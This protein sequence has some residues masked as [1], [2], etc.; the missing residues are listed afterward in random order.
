[1][2]HGKPVYGTIFYILASLNIKIQDG[3]R[4][5]YSK[6]NLKTNGHRNQCNTTFPTKCGMESEFLASL[7]YFDQNSRWPPST[8]SISAVVNVVVLLSFELCGIAMCAIPH[9][10][11]NFTWES[12]LK[13]NLL[14]LYGDFISKSIMTFAKKV[15]NKLSK[16][17]IVNKVKS[18]W[19]SSQGDHQK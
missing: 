3:R 5:P 6:C 15:T 4:Q 2:W 1:M 13:Q 18:R 14:I 12:H 11:L 17:T 10:L 8:I 19:I 9:S 7:L 16:L